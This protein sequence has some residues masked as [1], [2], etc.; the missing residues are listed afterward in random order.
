MVF[1][2]GETIFNYMGGKWMPSATGRVE[3]SINPARLQEVVGY[4]QTSSIEDLNQAVEAAS[5][6]KKAWRKLSAPA[7]GEYLYRVA[8]LLEQRLLEV[9]ETMTREMG[10]TFV[11]AKGETARGVAILRYYAA[12]GM[13]KVGDVIPS[14]DSSALMYTTRVPLGVVGVITPWNFPVAI[15]LWKIAPALIYG[16]TVVFKPASETA[17]TAA[18]IMRCFHEAS[19]PTGVINMVTGK[20][21]VIGQG[22]I[23]HSSVNG[24]TFTGSNETG[25]RVAYGAI[26]RGAKYQLE[27]GGKN[28][29]I[30]AE[31][32]D[33]D[34]AV[35]ATVNGGLRS[36]GQKCTAT[37]RVIVVSAVYEVFKEKLLQ[38]VRQIK[39]GD[40]MNPDIWMG[41]AANESQYQTVLSYMKAGIEAGASLIYGDQTTERN[42]NGYFLKPA[43]FE[44]V[45]NEMSI[46]R[47]E[48]FGPVL[49]LMKAHSFEEAIEMANDSE[50]G[51]SASVFTKNIGSMLEFVN[52]MEAGL[53]RIN[54]ESAGVELQAPFGGM[55]QSSSH[56]REQGQA[57]IE[58]FT[59]I[60]TVFVKP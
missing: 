9:A 4:V 28:P 14:T 56:S 54:S 31:D 57:A 40:G 7:R 35:E 39:V 16:N 23:D 55:K 48:I 42:E 51:L 24:I 29:I 8:D 15:P 27:M 11:E 26:H 5:L 12:E 25:K 45:S 43:I 19:L 60:K 3:S 10:K 13:R 21:S 37:S 20:G 22:I 41:P 18:Q 17:V 38:R 53:V 50:F 32:A 47:E 49:V 52:E 2:A 36:T 34:D 59:S 46:V 30:V 6:A 58:F 1:Q 33:L 44:N